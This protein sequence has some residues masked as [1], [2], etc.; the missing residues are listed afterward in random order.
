VKSISP[1]Q[2]LEIVTH[3]I[4]SVGVVLI[5]GCA[6]LTV[7]SLFALLTSFVSFSFLPRLLESFAFAF[8]ALWIFA[9][10]IANTV[11]ARTRSAKAVVGGVE[12]PAALVQQA[13]QAIGVSTAYW[14]NN[15][16]KCPLS[17]VPVIAFW[18]TGASL[19]RFYTIVT[20]I[21]L[22]FAMLSTIVSLTSKSKRNESKA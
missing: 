3:D 20:W 10:D 22:L 2:G 21:T 13:S 11:I 18:L 8:W 7:T 5:I 14:S 17:R 4:F 1:I 15:F 12:L 19:V 6:G 16:G 9:C